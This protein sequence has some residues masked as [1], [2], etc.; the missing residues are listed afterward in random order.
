MA[1]E[2]TEEIHLVTHQRTWPHFKSV[3][4][5]ENLVHLICHQ[6]KADMDFFFFWYN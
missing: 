4:A 2:E 6:T 5:V 1:G 3:I